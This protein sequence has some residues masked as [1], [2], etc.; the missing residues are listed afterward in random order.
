MGLTS[1]ST[2]FSRSLI[3][4]L[5]FSC[6]VPRFCS[7]SLR[8]VSLFARRDWL[9]SSENARV[10]WLFADSKA[11]SRSRASASCVWMRS[12]RERLRRRLT[13]QVTSAP[14]TMPS[15]SAGKPYS[16]RNGS[17]GIEFIRRP[18]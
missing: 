5:A 12:S 8:K 10:I 9:A 1:D 13:S 18:D 2:A 14:S 7:A 6:W 4:R 16:S 15:A 11:I 17:I 3:S